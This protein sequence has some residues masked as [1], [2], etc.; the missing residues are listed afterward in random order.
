M[1]TFTRTLVP[2]LTIAVVLLA[3]V[4]NAPANPAFRESGSEVVDVMEVY[5]GTVNMNQCCDCHSTY[6]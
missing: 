2:V 4:T 6:C 3:T 1:P 5:L